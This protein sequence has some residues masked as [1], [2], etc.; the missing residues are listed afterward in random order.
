[1]LSI[2][3]NR[4]PSRAAAVTFFCKATLLQLRRGCIDIVSGV[5]RLSAGSSTDFPFLLAE[6]RTTLWIEENLAEKSLQ[7]GKVENLRRALRQ[8]NGAAIADGGL[9]SFWKQIGRATLRRGYVP[10]R[11]MREGCLF[12]AIGGGLCQLSNA[13]YDV[14]LQAECEIVERHPHS[15]IVPGSAAA[16]DRDAAIAWNYL[17]LRFRPS[18]PMLVEARMTSDELIVR[19]YGQSAPPQSL[20]MPPLVNMP[21]NYVSLAS[22]TNPLI[23]DTRKILDPAAHSCLT[24]EQDACFRHNFRMVKTFLSGNEDGKEDG[25]KAYLVGECTPEFQEHLQRHRRAADLLAIPLDGKIWRQ[26][27]YAWDTAVYHSVGT[28]TVQT[29]RRSVISRRL[30]K[31]GAARLQAQLEGDEALAKRLAATLTPDVTRVCVAQSLLP[32]LWRDGHLGGRRFDVL[33]T[34]RPLQTLHENLDEALAQHPI[35]STLGEFRAPDWLVESEA[36]ALAAADT[37]ITPHTGIAALYPDKTLLLDWKLPDSSASS[38]S[39]SSGTIPSAL[40]S[41]KIVFPG[42]TAARKGAYELRDIARELDLEIVLLGGELE[43]DGFWEGVRTCR[44]G[45]GSTDWLTGIAAV[46]QP[47]L[48]E[49]HPRTL[50]RALAAGVPVI[51]TSACGIERLPGVQT[52]QYGDIDSLRS[53]LLNVLPGVSVTGLYG[54]ER[55]MMTRVGR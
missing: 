45:R 21:A 16:R 22:L 7:L 5:H 19:L 1:M 27:R 4:L 13:L 24:C 35:R 47:A 18:Q 40:A 3:E 37:L 43:G 10:G 8:L 49:D 17:D 51:A 11:Q 30:G 25:R 36:E 20:S 52:V 26:Q 41:R 23:R 14:A 9:F 28:A 55:A 44:S 31:Y 46:V 53:A 42:P 39:A 2:P 38:S 48:V 15:R 34:R 32:Y 29:V 54:I 33:M 50:L 6:S 12:P